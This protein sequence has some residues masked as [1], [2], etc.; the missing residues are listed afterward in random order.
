MLNFTLPVAQSFKKQDKLIEEEELLRE[1]KR[2]V[3]FFKVCT[4]NEVKALSSELTKKKE[5]HF[6]RTSRWQA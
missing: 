4:F 3:L 2:E 6:L 1:C 5:A